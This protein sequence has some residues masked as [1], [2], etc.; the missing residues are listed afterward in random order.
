MSIEKTVP[1]T[2][3]GFSREVCGRNLWHAAISAL[4]FFV[5]LAIARS[6]SHHAAA[7]REVLDWLPD[8]WGIGAV[9]VWVG[10]GIYSVVRLMCALFRSYRAECPDCRCAVD[11]IAEQ[12]DK[13]L[14]C[15]GCK[16][17]L[18]Q[19]KDWLHHIADDCVLD[20]PSFSTV[21]P[22]NPTLPSRCCVCMGVEARR[23][24]HNWTV[25]FPPRTGQSQPTAY[26]HSLDLPYCAEHRDGVEILEWPGGRS[27][28]FRSYSYLQEFCK[29]NGTAPQ[30]R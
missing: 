25:K 22:E 24:P 2:R 18:R 16:R 1:A 17:C 15:S 4:V 7:A 19:D 8:G 21:L 9:I 23:L 14:V 27:I 28:G 29:V 12:A 5:A 6:A 3:I 10:V 20:V 11:G 30:S 13:I 26:E